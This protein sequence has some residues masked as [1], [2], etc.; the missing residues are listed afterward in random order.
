VFLGRGLKIEMP[1]PVHCPEAIFLPH[2]K[3]LSLRSG[4]RGYALADIAPAG[5]FVYGPEKFFKGD[6]PHAVRTSPN[7]SG[8]WARM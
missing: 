4:L 3:S 7:S 6:Q 2:E 8:L 5:F 1:S